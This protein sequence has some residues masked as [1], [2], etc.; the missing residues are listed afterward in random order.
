[1]KHIG[2]DNLAT[3]KPDFSVLKLEESVLESTR[4]H[5]NQTP[6]TVED[7]SGVQDSGIEVSRFSSSPTGISSIRKSSESTEAVILNAPSTS[8]IARDVKVPIPIKPKIMEPTGS[9]AST[10]ASLST[11]ASASTSM[12][13]ASMGKRRSGKKEFDCSYCGKVF[14]R[15][16][17]LQRH[18]LTH[19]G[20]RPFLCKYCGKG[21]STRS[22]VNT[23]ERIHTGDKP[24]VC[25]HCGRRFTAGSNYTFHVYIHNNTRPHRCDECDKAFVT[26]G[27]LRRHKYVHSGDWPFTCSVCGR[28]FAIERSLNNHMAIHSG[29]K[30]YSCNI[31]SKSYTQES[32][33]KTHMRIHQKESTTQMNTPSTSNQDNPPQSSSCSSQQP[34]QQPAV[35]STEVPA[36]NAPIQMPI[37]PPLG[38]LT[39]WLGMPPSLT[40]LQLDN[41]RP[42]SD[43]ENQVQ[44]LQQQFP[45]M[46]T[47]LANAVLPTSDRSAFVDLR[48]QRAPFSSGDL[49]RHPPPNRSGQPHHQKRQRRRLSP[50]LQM[51]PIDLSNRRSRR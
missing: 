47:P 41:A 45:H 31:C 15:P 35:T 40:E 42:S 18:I 13:N 32:S 4:L 7:G 30:P 12:P 10:S 19:T 26:P 3:P 20:E 28:G 39:Q 2:S 23:H 49:L 48:Q 11:S 43:S 21:F 1:M 51:Q 16:S 17:L 22:G 8:M 6:K 14:D 34:V 9:E 50:S 27:D 46:Y 24:Y 5:P 44:G 29:V 25:A 37:I 38:F 33:L 36:L